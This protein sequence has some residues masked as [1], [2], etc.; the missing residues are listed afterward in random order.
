MIKTARATTVDV[1][2]ELKFRSPSGDFYHEPPLILT[3]YF[4]DQ[5]S[6]IHS[7]S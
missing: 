1:Q 4:M 2:P 3:T 5:I 7:V 6:T